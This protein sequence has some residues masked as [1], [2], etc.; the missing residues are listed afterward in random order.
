MAKL[1]DMD[2]DAFKHNDQEIKMSFGFYEDFLAF[3]TDHELRHKA[4]DVFHGT[5]KKYENTNIKT[6]IPFY[7][8]VKTKNKI[9][10]WYDTNKRVTYSSLIIRGFIK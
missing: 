2:F 8:D 4:F 9:W 3:E 10:R 1:V 6:P 7:K 5:L